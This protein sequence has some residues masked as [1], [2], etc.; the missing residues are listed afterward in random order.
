MKD[1]HPTSKPGV[2][3]KI[4]NSLKGRTFLS[5]G[6]NGAITKQQLALQSLLRL[7]DE[8]LEYPI[9]TAPVAGGFVSLPP[10]Y[11]VDIGIPEI[12]LAIEVDGRS[13][14][15][16]RQRWIDHR[17]TEVLRAL[18]WSVIRFW[19]REIDDDPR[20]VIKKIISWIDS[21]TGQTP[22]GVDLNALLAAQKA[23]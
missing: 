23:L 15:A 9:L 1:H 3:E 20:G 19:N 4:S 22:S 16:K 6:G 14:I 12:K 10:A 5:R 21:E 18:G 8:S 7:G 11:K 17:K 13:H 2:S